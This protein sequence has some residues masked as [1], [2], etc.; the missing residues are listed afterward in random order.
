[1]SL[2]DPFTYAEFVSEYG[3]QSFRRGRLAGEVYQSARGEYRFITTEEEFVRL[4]ERGELL[5]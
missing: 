1:M 5:S 4:L 2:P 3:V